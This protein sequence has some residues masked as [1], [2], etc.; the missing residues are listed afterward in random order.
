MQVPSVEKESFSGIFFFLWVCQKMKQTTIKSKATSIVSKT[1]R[2]KSRKERREVNERALYCKR[3]RKVNE[4]IVRQHM[5]K[6]K[7]TKKKCVSSVGR[8]S[9]SF[10]SECLMKAVSQTQVCKFFCFVIA[11]ERSGRRAYT[12]VMWCVRWKNEEGESLNWKL[13]ENHFLRWNERADW[14]IYRH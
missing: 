3:K 13:K 7:S 14:N 10:C 5:K 9:R 6:R 2:R 11:W 8:E 12:E 1:R 4:I